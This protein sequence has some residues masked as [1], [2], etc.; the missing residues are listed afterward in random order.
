MICSTFEDVTQKHDIFFDRKFYENFEDKI[1]DLFNNN[2]NTNYLDKMNNDTTGVLH[3]ALA[4]YYY[5]VLNDHESHNKLHEQAF[6]YNFVMAIFNR[7]VFGR[8]K[9]IG[10]NEKICLLEKCLSIDPD[11][12]LCYNYLAKEYLISD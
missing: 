11:F 4:L 7:A 12:L 9:E 8:F 1:V 5:Y 3:E 6:N 2:I 10:R